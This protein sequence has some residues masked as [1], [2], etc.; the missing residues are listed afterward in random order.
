MS[1]GGFRYEKRNN[2]GVS[3]LD[4]KVAYELSVVNSYFKK[5]WK[6]LVTF[7]SGNTRTL[8]DSFR[9]KVNDKGSGKDY[10]VIPTESIMMQHRLLVTD[11]EIK[12]VR[13]RRETSTTLEL[14]DG[15]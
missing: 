10:K 1:H 9:V 4:F 3:I 7:K 5:K 6:H 12:C 15:I 8:I 13:E 11:V 14:N 2:V